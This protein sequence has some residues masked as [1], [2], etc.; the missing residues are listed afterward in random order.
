MRVVAK[1]VGR[2]V[3]DHVAIASRKPDRFFWRFC[4]QPAGTCDHETKP[5]RLAFPEADRPWRAG[6]EPRIE[7]F[8]NPH[9]R[10]RVVQRIH[11]LFLRVSELDARTIFYSKWPFIVQ[12]FRLSFPTPL[13][14]PS[15]HENGE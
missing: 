8:A 6:V 4:R 14:K 1:R 13:W 9:R 12:N 3:Q 7:R 2:A 11:G 10:K 5:G 15:Q